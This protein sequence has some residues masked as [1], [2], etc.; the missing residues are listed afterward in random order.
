[1]KSQFFRI[2]NSDDQ[3]NK[4]FFL[5]FEK[6][7]KID[8]KKAEYLLINTNKLFD[9][10]TKDQRRAFALEAEKQTGLE[11]GIIDIFYNMLFFLS[12]FYTEN[13]IPVDDADL[14]EADIIENK[15]LQSFNKPNASI[16]LHAVFEKLQDQCIDSFKK[17]KSK[18]GVLPSFSQLSS[19]VELRAR[20]VNEYRSGLSANSYTP[21]VKGFFPVAS[22]ALY[23]D[24]NSDP[25]FFTASKEQVEVILEKMKAIVKELEAVEQYIRK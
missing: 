4:G 7:L 20:L 1:M 22:F 12:R 19:T 6:I 2:F 8:P 11:L 15:L 5:D 25:F 23:S 13:E 21:T 16:V 24:S 17:Q 3:D 18:Y 9:S 10:E 14:I